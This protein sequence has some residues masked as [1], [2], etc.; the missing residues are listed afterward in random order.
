MSNIT[1]DQMR[2][3]L[4]NITQLQELLFGEQIEK[5]DR[6][7]AEHNQK[8]DRIEL[9]QGEFQST[10]KASLE[11]LENKLTSQIDAVSNTLEKRLKYL[12]LNTQQDQNRIQEE[13]DSVSQYSYENIDFLQNNINTHTNNLKTEISQSKAAIDRDLQLLKQ[14]LVEK[15]EFNLKQLSTGKVS[16]QDLAEVLFELCVKLKE[17]NGDL[18]WKESVNNSDR[19]GL[20]LPENTSDTNN[21]Q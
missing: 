13:L 21:E 5:Y 16:R 17:P 6:A 2:Q 18:E 12:E 1:K 3:K 10:I 20:M 9:Q 8:L 14:Q 11:Q 7:L 15:I 19:P 4:G